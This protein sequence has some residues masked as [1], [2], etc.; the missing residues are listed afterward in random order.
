M[1][2]WDVVIFSP[3]LQFL[4]MIINLS[5]FKTFI[6]SAAAV[7]LFVMM[8]CATIL[9]QVTT[10]ISTSLSVHSVELVYQKQH[11]SRL[12]PYGNQKLVFRLDCMQMKM[13]N[14]YSSQ[15]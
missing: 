12:L 1:I 8:Y 5:F 13:N 3:G 10:G 11:V 2:Y 9:A 6:S 14:F 4:I 15:V 7:T